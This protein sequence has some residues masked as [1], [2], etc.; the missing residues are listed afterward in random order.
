MRR[1]KRFKYLYPIYTIFKWRL[2]FKCNMEFRREL[3]YKGIINK[4]DLYLCNHCAPTREDADKIFFDKLNSKEGDN[5][6]VN[7]YSPKIIQHRM[8]YLGEKAEGEGK[9]KKTRGRRKRG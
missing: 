4:V 9:V 3:G 8:N 5:L 2:C 6:K 7:R 1:N